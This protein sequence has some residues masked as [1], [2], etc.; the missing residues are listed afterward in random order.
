MINETSWYSSEQLNKS[1][2]EDIE[3]RLIRNN[4]DKNIAIKEKKNVKYPN[5]WYLLSNTAAYEITDIV[6]SNN[7]KKSSINNK[8]S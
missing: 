8:T 6:I 2:Y 7:K 3:Q 1:I 5:Y 4:A